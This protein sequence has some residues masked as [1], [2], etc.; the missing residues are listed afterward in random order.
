MEVSHPTALAVKRSAWQ[1]LEMED[2]DWQFSSAVRLET[3]LAHC[4]A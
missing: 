4:R 3:G 2:L 1:A